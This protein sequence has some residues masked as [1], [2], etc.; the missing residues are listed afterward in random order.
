MRH[1][2][3]ERVREELRL[4]SAHLGR[5]SEALVKELSQARRNWSV[6]VEMNELAY[7]S[8]IPRIHV[9]VDDEEV[10]FPGAMHKVV[11]NEDGPLY[12]PKVYMVHRESGEYSDWTCD[13]NGIFSTYEAARRYVEHRLTVKCYHYVGQIGDRH[14]MI[15][16]DQWRMSDHLYSYFES[17]SE[18][19]PEIVE[20]GMTHPVEKDAYTFWEAYPDGE[21]VWG[22]CGSERTWFITEYTI[23]EP[24][25]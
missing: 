18:V 15:D 6:E 20:T 17:T 3:E 14:G 22:S 5:N 24:V 1:S 9:G 4:I 16:I 10:D 19:V 21:R 8:D 25:E 12:G 13:V 23:D 7:D 11:A 2:T